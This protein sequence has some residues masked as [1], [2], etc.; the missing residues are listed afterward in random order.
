M[1]D[2]LTI[3]QKQIENLIY[4]VRNVQVMLDFDLAEIY[5]V[6]TRALNQAVNRNVERFPDDFMF[7]LTQPEWENLKSHFVISSQHGG[8]RTLP[9]AFTEQGVSGLSG[10]LKT[11]T[12]SRIHVAIMRKFCAIDLRK[13]WTTFSKM[14]NEPVE[15]MMN[16]IKEMI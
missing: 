14:K 6:E 4:T 15:S 3:S 12:A 2:E 16:E 13:E 8:R 10:V 11:K 9:F 1:R 5:Q 7:Q